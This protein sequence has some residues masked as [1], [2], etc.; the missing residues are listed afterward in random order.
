MVQ[1][2]IEVDSLNNFKN[3]LMVSV[4]KNR[5]GSFNSSDVSLY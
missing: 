5:E 3:E 2:C 1:V 4:K